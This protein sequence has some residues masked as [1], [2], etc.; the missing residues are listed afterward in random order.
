MD[1]NP[2]TAK[3]QYEL[4]LK[5]FRGDGVPKD[6]D[7]AIYWYTEAAEQGNSYAQVN[8]GLCYLHR[9]NAVDALGNSVLEALL[10]ENLR[11]AAYWFTKAAEQGD[12]QG[13]FN[14]A[15]LYE[16]GA[17]VYQNTEQAKYWYAK[18]AEQGNAA[19]Q[20]RLKNLNEGSYAGCIMVILGLVIIVAT[21]LFFTISASYKQKEQEAAE[22]KLAAQRADSIRIVNEMELM[23]KADSINKQEKENR[24]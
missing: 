23:R 6:Y 18:A 9:I 7:K 10:G 16:N 22:A 13:Q 5:Y 2:T 14:I 15:N 11:K 21:Y 17:G 4:G 3:E 20:K 1:E 19:A 8:L 12:V 24:K